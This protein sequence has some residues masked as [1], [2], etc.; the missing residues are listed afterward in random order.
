MEGEVSG[1]ETVHPIWRQCTPS[2]DSAPLLTLSFF[3][4]RFLP[5]FQEDDVMD[6]LQKRREILHK[7]AVG[8]TDIHLVLHRY[9][10]MD[11]L[12]KIRD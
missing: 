11:E 12:Q 9:A 3:T 1:L 6:G 4:T 8:S 5:F 2:G 7:Y 10:V